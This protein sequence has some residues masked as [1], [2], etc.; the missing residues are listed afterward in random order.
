MS[1]RRDE[2]LSSREVRSRSQ[3]R[4][5]TV[6][7]ELTAQDLEFGVVVRLAVRLRDDMDDGAHR[8]AA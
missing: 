6:P 4:E 7:V 1:D 8:R 2:M 3:A 5:I